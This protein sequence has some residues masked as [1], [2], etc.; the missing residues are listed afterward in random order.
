M[1]STAVSR[2]ESMTTSPNKQS[3][4]L[5]MRERLRKTFSLRGKSSSSSSDPADHSAKPASRSHRHKSSRPIKSAPDALYY[6]PGE[7]LPLKYRRPVEKA[8]EELL[9]AFSWSQNER[10][11]SIS[12]QYSPM[13]SRMPSRNGSLEDPQ[14]WVMEGRVVNRPWSNG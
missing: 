12:S 8:H 11:T 13:G 3:N 1:L 6:L 2:T 5:P 9:A 7:K 4:K 14:I 10:R